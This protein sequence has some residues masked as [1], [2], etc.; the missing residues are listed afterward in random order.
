M[1]E[2]IL[3]GRVWQGELVDRR[4]DGGLYTVD[5][6]IT[7]LVDSTSTVTHFVAI[8]H[9][10]SEAAHQRDDIRK[11]AYSDS[12]TGLP[13]RVLILE[14]LTQAIG[15]ASARGQMLAVMFLDLDHFKPVNDTHGHALGDKLLRAVAARL[16]S[17]IRKTDTVA[18]LGGDEFVI[19][20]GNLEVLE[21]ATV[22]AQKLV[23]SIGQ[24]FDVD[25]CTVSTGASIGISLYP[26]HGDAAETLIDRAD[27]AMYRAKTTGR[28]RYCF[29]DS[30]CDAVTGS[31]P[32]PR[33]GGGG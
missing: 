18:R 33:A 19:V 17:A 12:L 26:E 10:I 28:S 1:W 15:Q 11:L 30:A 2:T 3:S 8:Q 25:G 27:A 32:L 20:I 7:P 13:N 14:M 21:V 9:D 24:P 5:Q 29:F 4:R 31:R 23:D 16:R 6:V 22:L